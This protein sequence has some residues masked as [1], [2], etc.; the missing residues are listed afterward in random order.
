MFGGRVLAGPI[1]RHA[2]SDGDVTRMVS[3]HAGGVVPCDAI[4]KP[5]FV[6][7]GSEFRVRITVTRLLLFC[8][9][10]LLCR[11]S[12]FYVFIFLRPE[13]KEIAEAWQIESTASCGRVFGRANFD[14]DHFE[15]S[16]KSE[17]VVR[18]AGFSREAAE[19]AHER[20]LVVGG[21]F[22]KEKAIL[23]RCGGG[24]PDVSPPRR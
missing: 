2:A 6:P 16:V 21:D 19:P 7:R 18:T 3:Q 4:G 23:G 10:R 5:A 9:R 24:S 22:G 11:R 15:R 17:L 20:H 1:R 14:V 13:S 12:R 8:C